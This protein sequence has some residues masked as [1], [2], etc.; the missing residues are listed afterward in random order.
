MAT[1]IGVPITIM[2][3][4]E[5]IDLFKGGLKM[6]LCFTDT[7]I[8]IL[9]DNMKGTIGLYYGLEAWGKFLQYY[10]AMF[11]K[12]L[13]QYK[14]QINSFGYAV[15]EKLSLPLMKDIGIL[16]KLCNEGRT[17]QTLHKLRLYRHHIQY[18]LSKPSIEWTEEAMKV[19]IYSVIQQESTKIKEKVNDPELANKLRV[20]TNQALVL[21]PSRSKESQNSA[22]DLSLPKQQ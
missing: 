22:L 14:G 4:E 13:V 10:L 5:R 17:P 16:M 19:H 21:N 8:E 12:T 1:N 9:N 3:K 18:L 6:L 11:E 2:T 7:A 20:V 15:A